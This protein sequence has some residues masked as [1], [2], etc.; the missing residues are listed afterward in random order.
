MPYEHVDILNKDVDVAVTKL[1]EVAR[2]LRA[3]RFVFD[4]IDSLERLLRVRI[5]LESPRLD[6]E[7][8]HDE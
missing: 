6:K 7:T 4:E 3:T 1:R 5:T 8:K 2:T